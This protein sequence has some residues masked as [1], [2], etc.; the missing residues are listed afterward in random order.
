MR[1]IL[2]RN[3]IARIFAL[4]LAAMFIATSATF[5]AAQSSSPQAAQ[6]KSSPAQ[7]MQMT[8]V[9]DKFVT[10]Y[11]ARIHYVEAGSGPVVILV[12]GLGA[13]VSSWAMTI[14]PLS[15]K[16]RV[17][18]LDQIGFGKSD[19]PMLNYRVGTLVDFLDGFY[20]EMKIDRAS[21]VGNSLGGWTVAAF[22]LAHPEKVDRLVMVDAAGFKIAEGFDPRIAVWLNPATLADTKQIL[23]LIFYNKQIFVN[24]ATA[25]MML[26]RRVQTNDGYT[27]QRF[28]DSIMRGEDVLDD[29]LSAIKQPTLIV[30]GREDGLT[31]IAM[32]ERFKK[33]I[34]GSQLLVFDK[35]GHVPQI[36]KAADF[37]AAVMKFLGGETASK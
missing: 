10:V 26:T 8:G 19:K 3:S 5:T 9:T 17:I 36:E 31:P 30:W 13:D 37:N 11:G 29:R 12:H 35:C 33:E 21:L 27:I 20:K 1:N 28:I 2:S 22:A 6:D 18:A 34:P 25:A 16:Y 4:M 24:D 23:S 32:G 15:K 14:G 7:M